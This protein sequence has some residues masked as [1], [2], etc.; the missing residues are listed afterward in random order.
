MVWFLSTARRG[1]K[2][3]APRQGRLPVITPAMRKGW[4]QIPRAA[5]IGAVR[6]YA[7]IIGSLWSDQS[8]DLEL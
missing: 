8:R 1:R 3:R 5:G 6:I 7:K 4:R 2:F